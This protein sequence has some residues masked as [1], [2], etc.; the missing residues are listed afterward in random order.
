MSS[1][2][3]S[4]ELMAALQG[5]AEEHIDI[6][7]MVQTKVAAFD[8]AELEAIVYRVAATEFRAIEWWGALLGALIGI[9][10]AILFACLA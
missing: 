3:D 7:G 9:G 8:M 2:I 6:A 4:Q 1:V 10:Q 5:M